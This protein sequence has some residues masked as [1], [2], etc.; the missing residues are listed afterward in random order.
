M[1]CYQIIYLNSSEK[2]T[3]FTNNITCRALRTD[4]FSELNRS[5]RVVFRNDL[6]WLDF[7]VL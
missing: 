6:D 7:H 5:A 4:I 3:N 1:T 2:K